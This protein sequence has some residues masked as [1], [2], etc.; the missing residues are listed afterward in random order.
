MQTIAATER[1][2][3][4][5]NFG[6]KFQLGEVENGEKPQ[7]DDSQWRQLDLPYDYQLNMPWEKRQT[8]PGLSKICLVHGSV[9]H[10]I[11]TRRGKIV[12]YLLIL[13]E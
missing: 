13:K 1:E 3:I 9:R 2:V 10:S 8:V 11:Q 4:L 12:K 5:M 7:L 6:W